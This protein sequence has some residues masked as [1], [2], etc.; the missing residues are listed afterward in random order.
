MR[1]L[2][3]V[4][5]IIVLGASVSGCAF[6]SRATDWS[7]LSGLDRKPT[8]YINTTK[9]GFNLLVFVP[10]IGDMGISGMVRD[11]TD[12]IK[13]EGGEQVRI[14]QG[15]SENYWYGWPPF[16]WVL[17]PVIATVAAEYEPMA[18]KYDEEQAEI[19]KVREEGGTGRWYMPWTW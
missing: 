15:A 3:T 14:V 18:S 19:R 17:T 10:F 16:T 5:G 12:E 11:M 2:E 6:S 7:D 13:T 9:I 4:C 8:Y 1:S